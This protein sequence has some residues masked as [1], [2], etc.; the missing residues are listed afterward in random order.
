M[1]ITTE[2]TYWMAA[3]SGGWGDPGGGLPAPGYPGALAMFSDDTHTLLMKGSDEDKL[4]TI[5]E[6]DVY[7]DIKKVIPDIINC[8]RLKSGDYLIKV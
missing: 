2:G 4:K 1:A 5:R 3:S 8:K 7:I 6:R